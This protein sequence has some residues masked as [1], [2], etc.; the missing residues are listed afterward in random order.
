MNFMQRKYWNN[1]TCTKD[2]IFNA[3]SQ[4]EQG[5]I[6]GLTDMHE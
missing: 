2:M 1:E 4:L 5:K 6:N 3:F